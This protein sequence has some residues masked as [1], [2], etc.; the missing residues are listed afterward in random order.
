MTAGLGR[1][2]RLLLAFARFSLTQELAFRGNFLIKV[3]VEVLWL[4]ILII[5]YDTIFSKTTSVAGW[6]REEYLFFVGCY[7]ALEGMIET[8]F[9]SNCSEFADLIRSGDLDFYLL[10]PIDEQ[11]LLTCRT[12]DWS[13]VPNV[14]MGV[15]VMAYALREMGWA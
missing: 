10:K 1:Y 5:F 3:L 4:T 2:V 7:F 12:I 15:G 14:L 13:T 11:F 6:S 8:L 9:L